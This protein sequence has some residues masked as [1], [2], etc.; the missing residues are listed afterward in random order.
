MSSAVDSTPSSNPRSIVCS[1]NRSEWVI[2]SFG[3]CVVPT[4]F[5]DENVR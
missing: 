3:S 2:V 4:T 5:V 1:S